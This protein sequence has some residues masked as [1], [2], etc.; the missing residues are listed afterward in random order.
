MEIRYDRKADAIYV[1]LTSAAYAY[2][3]DLDSERR[4]DYDSNGKPRGIELT[5]VSR[6]VNLDDLPN[7]VELERRLKLHNIKVFV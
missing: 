6:G 1:H 7:N 2:G 3:K 4:I 5:C